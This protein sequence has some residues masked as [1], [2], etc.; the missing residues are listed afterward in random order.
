MKH[1]Y[2]LF[3]LEDNPSDDDIRR[4]Y[5]QM[6]QQYPPETH[7]VEFQEISDAYN[8]I[9]DPEERASF[10]LFGFLPESVERVPDIITDD[11]NCRN[12]VGCK[13]WMDLLKESQ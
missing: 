13:L 9:K 1:P 8:L 7:P 6:I 4:A 5:R 12:R 3:D 2:I 10:N 11:E